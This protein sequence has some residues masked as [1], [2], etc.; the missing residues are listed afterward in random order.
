LLHAGDEQRQE[1]LAPADYVELA[2]AF[3]KLRSELREAD[4][5]DD[6]TMF[7][8]LAAAG[9][10]L[11]DPAT[12]E[13]LSWYNSAWE[14]L[15]L[16]GVWAASQKA[17]RGFVLYELGQLDPD[18]LQSVPI[19]ILTRALRGMAFLQYSWPY[20]SELE[21]TAY[22]DDLAE[23]RE[24]MLSFGRQSSR[25]AGRSDEQIYAQ[26][27]A[28]GVLLRGGARMGKGD[29]FEEEMLG[30]LELFLKDAETLGLDEEV[31]WLIAAYVGIKREDPER[32]LPALRKLAQSELF[33]AEEQRLFSD[34][35]DAVENRDPDAALASLS[36]KYL[37]TKV[38]GS[39]V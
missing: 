28:I 6:P 24:E 30:D 33:P 14:H 15:L 3:Y 29:E 39:Y 20:M 34:A 27:H 19:R 2:A 4:E 35:A 16:A 1:K 23:H 13:T 12:V 32:S 17:P 11:R 22:L 9:G 21:M 37:L 36:D 38:V 18:E 5:D 25:V 10:T 7:E 8:Q 31:V 26:W